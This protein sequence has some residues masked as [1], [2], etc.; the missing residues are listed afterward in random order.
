MHMTFYEFF[1]FFYFILINLDAATEAQIF[2]N[3]FIPTRLFP[4]KQISTKK[5]SH[6][7]G[8]LCISFYIKCNILSFE[9]SLL[10]FFTLIVIKNK[11][12]LN[13]FF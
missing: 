13:K 2:K 4:H 11:M 3:F 6:L 1:D 5:Y 12:D 7:F 9:E 10:H 8:S